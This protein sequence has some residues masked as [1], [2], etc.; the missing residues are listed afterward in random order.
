MS[1]HDYTHT[2]SLQALENLLTPFNEIKKPH[3]THI[4]SRNKILA[5]VQKKA[6]QPPIIGRLALKDTQK[7]PRIR[8]TNKHS[9]FMLEEKIP[10]HILVH[11]LLSEA[12]LSKGRKNSYLEAWQNMIKV[13]KNGLPFMLVQIKTPI[14]FWVITLLSLFLRLHPWVTWYVQ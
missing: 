12:H 6:R 13:K 4:W 1:A 8:T 11:M 9:Q 7:Q 10:S 14:L 3:D 5:S 2:H